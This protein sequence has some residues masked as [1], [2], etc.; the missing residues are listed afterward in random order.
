MTENETDKAR[1]TRLITEWALDILENGRQVIAKD[2]SVVTMKAG[3]SD[4][5]EARAWLSN[6]ESNPNVDI[7]GDSG[8]AELARRAKM[9]FEGRE[10]PS[11]DDELADTGS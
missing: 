4:I 2:G 11:M 10:V 1:I 3:P 6:L 5:R 8:M 7:A 9:R